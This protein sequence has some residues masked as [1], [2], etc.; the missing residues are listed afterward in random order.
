[1]RHV[2]RVPKNLGTSRKP[3]SALRV[4][5]MRTS[6]SL[7]MCHVPAR[8]FPPDD[9][10]VRHLSRAADHPGI[11]RQPRKPSPEDPPPRALG[12]CATCPGSLFFRTKFQKIKQNV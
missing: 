5:R 8:D 12:E 6:G 9:L 11:A 3:P 10:R 1:M 2:S 7:R 4:Q